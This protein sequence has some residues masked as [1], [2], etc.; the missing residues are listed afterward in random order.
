MNPTNHWK[1][2][3]FV[4]ASVVLLFL[5]AFYLGARRLA[6]DKIVVTSYFDESVQ[7]LDVGSPVK[8]RGVQ[9]GRV[10]GIAF[11]RDQRLVKVESF[12]YQDTLTRI[13]LGGGSGVDPGEIPED[14]AVRLAS[15]GITGVRFLEV[16]FLDPISH[17]HI[18]LPFREPINYL[19][20]T[21]STLKGLEDTLNTFAIKLPQVMDKAVALMTTIDERVGA[22]DTAGISTNLIETLDLL[23]ARLTALDTEGLTSDAR[24]AL[25]DLRTLLQKLGFEGGPLDETLV[26]LAALAKTTEAAVGGADLPGTTAAVREAAASLG[27]LGPEAGRS[28]ADVQEALEATRRAMLALGELLDYIERDPGALIRGRV[29]ET[30]PPGQDD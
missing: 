25:A 10:K 19:P 7:G 3:V 13:G 5:S 11:A 29:Q 26:N 14:L 24:G 18:E 20:S 23:E 12:I 27:A 22:V 30:P 2:G 4:L 16:D 8:M 6:R 9:I 15:Q 17:P 21:T 1:L 28:L